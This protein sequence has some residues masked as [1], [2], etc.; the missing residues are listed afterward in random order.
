M[1]VEHGKTG[2]LAY[3]FGQRDGEFD[4]CTCADG[5]FV[6]AK[7]GAGN[8]NFLNET[9]RAR[10]LD[11]QAIG[12]RIHGR[13][14]EKTVFPQRDGRVGVV[15]AREKDEIAIGIE[16]KGDVARGKA[17]EFKFAGGNLGNAHGNAGGQRAEDFLGSADVGHAILAGGEIGDAQMNGGK[18]A[19]RDVGLL[20]VPGEK[21]ER[22]GGMFVS[23]AG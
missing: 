23:D 14:R 4:F 16:K 13:K 22:A 21:V 17:G 12:T 11:E 20:D 19:E 6:A 3:T 18:G 2:D 10:K 5:N 8:R 15:V 9:R 1:A 7:F